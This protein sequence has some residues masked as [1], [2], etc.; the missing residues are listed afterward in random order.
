LAK[1]QFHVHHVERALLNPPS[2]GASS[3]M[4]GKSRSFMRGDFAFAA[5]H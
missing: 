3:T 1:R 2:A 5:G 4:C